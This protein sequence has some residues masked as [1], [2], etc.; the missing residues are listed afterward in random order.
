MNKFFKKLAILFIVLAVIIGGGMYA[1]MTFA[2]MDYLQEKAKFVVKEKTGRDLA[3]AD[4]RISVWP[5]VGLTLK[6]VTFS[7]ADW[8]T[9]KNMVRLGEMDVHVA[10]R[11]LFEKRI[12]VIRFVMNQPEINLEVSPDGKKN[13]EFPAMAKEDKADKSSSESG[14]A[15]A[16]LAGFKLNEFV[17][18]KGKVTLNDRQQKKITSADTVNITVSFPDIESAFQ[19]DGSLNYLG[20]RIQLVMGVDKPKALMAGEPTPGSLI[21]KSD[22]LDATVAGTFA[23]AGTML[24]NGKI[25]AQVK[26]LSGLVGW[27]TQAQAGDLPFEK[28]SFVSGAQFTTDKLTLKGAGLVLDEIEAKGD[29]SL[30]VAGVRPQLVAR[31]SL[32]KI[33][34]DRFMGGGADA[35]KDAS[36]APA[37]SEPQGDWDATPIDF[38][39]LKAV[40]AD[41]VLQT[42]GF[43]VKGV[44]VGASTLTAVLKNGDLKASSSDASLFGGRFSSDVSLATSSGTPKQSFNFKMSDVQA[45]PV[46]VKF[47]DFG[48]LT[49]AADANVSVTSSG[50]SQKAIISALAGNGAVTFKNGALTGIDF[51]NI[52]TMI[53]R[54]LQDAAIGGG[55]T[56]F[57]D[58]GGTFKIAAGIVSNDD[59]RMRGPLVQASG[60]GTIDLPRKYLKYR[61]T[62]VLTASS[63]VDNAK[64]VR[65]PVDIVGPFSN[66]RVKPDFKAVIQ[67]TLKD[68]EALKA[69]GKALEQNFKDIKKDIKKDPGAAI[70]NLLGGGVGG[71]LG[72]SKKPAETAPVPADAAPVETAPADAAP[73]EQAPAESGTAP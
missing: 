56:E 21:V 1:L 62:P 45:Q 32:N 59:F 28:I 14:A 34:L 58:L 9:E 33:D 13:W 60:T 61:V 52:A 6:D 57:V 27:L 51:V 5:H 46:L 24:D 38:S 65:V 63:G 25:E 53:Q 3:F 41:V 2:P 55:K 70:Q 35:A 10:L 47:A 68:P 19:L 50:N 22:V 11:P 71:L 15:D 73:A 69:Q 39:G 67:D 42:Q 64:G 26:S 36:A 18:S 40:D 30:S 54:G 23:T 20:K 17:I 48:N 7:S 44:D 12:E 16:A 31:L 37:K 49:G 72:G 8:A 66:V 29:V 4:A 43:S